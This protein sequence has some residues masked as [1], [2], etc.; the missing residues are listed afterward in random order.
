M[1]GKAHMLGLKLNKQILPLKMQI[2]KAQGRQPV[3]SIAFAE[4]FERFSYYGTFSL[5][6]VFLSTNLG[7]TDSKTYATSA[8]FGAMGFALPVLGGIMADIMLGMQYLI[9]LGSIIAALGHVLMACS[10]IETTFYGLALI[11]LGTGLFKGNI[12]VLLGSCYADQD[13]RRSAAFTAFYASINAG[14]LA[15]SIA[16]AYCY[17][18]LGPTFGFALAGIGILTSL[19]IF[20]LFRSNLGKVGLEPSRAIQFRYKKCFVLISAALAFLACSWLI[21]RSESLVNLIAWSSGL[22]FLMYLL[23]ILQNEGRERNSLIVLGLLLIF[24]LIFY[25]FQSQIFFAIT[26]FTKR[27]VDTCIFGH[28]VPSTA[29]Q[30][31]PTISAITF[32]IIRSME[33]P[34][35][36][37]SLMK[38]FVELGIGL[39]GTMICFTLLY[40]GCVNSK[41]DKISCLYLVSTALIG[42][43]EILVGPFVYNQATLLAPKAF[44]GYSM[45]FVLLAIA[46][47]NLATAII[48]RP[49]SLDSTLELEASLPLYAKGFS[50]LALLQALML[51]LFCITVY[52][53]RNRIKAACSQP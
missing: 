8:L 39:M 37:K 2:A 38:G 13:P 3:V 15:S 11:A 22:F 12:T 21:A 18:S 51:G 20:L 24:S 14:A 48:S 53:M 9:I 10:R 42:V 7:F 33:K 31:I 44:K 47:G 17:Q 34:K 25:S 46:F 16:C 4:M 36:N 45:S 30:A 43:S 6:T 50:I 26:L 27:N 1:S 5:L 49:I 32:G 19:S 23:L 41:G 28:E 35:K 29:F 52:L 40:L